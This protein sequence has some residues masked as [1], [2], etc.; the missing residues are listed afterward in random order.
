MND[1]SVL[2]VAIVGVEG[3]DRIK[4]RKIIIQEAKEVDQMKWTPTWNER[5]I[6][7]YRREG[8]DTQDNAR[9]L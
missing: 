1:F 7:F 3:S 8:A 4:T 6:R 2:A 5:A 9:V